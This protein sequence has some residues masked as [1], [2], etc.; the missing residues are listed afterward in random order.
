MPVPLLTALVRVVSRCSRRVEAALVQPVLLHGFDS[1]VPLTRVV[2]AARLAG[3]GRAVLL[4]RVPRERDQLLRGSV[5]AR[6]YR[7]RRCQQSNSR[8]D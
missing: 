4:P 8:A 6:L 1:D 2:L 7:R 5:D 3:V